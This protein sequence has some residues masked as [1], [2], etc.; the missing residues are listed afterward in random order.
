MRPETATWR[1]K[2]KETTS[3][4]PLYVMMYNS[5]DVMNG[6]ATDLKMYSQL[7]GYCRTTQFVRYDIFMNWCALI[8]TDMPKDLPAGMTLIHTI[9]GSTKDHSGW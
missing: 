3:N 2:P 1:D 4:D 6:L 5:Q 9:M 7:D 8:I